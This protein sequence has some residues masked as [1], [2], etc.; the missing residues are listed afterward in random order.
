MIDHVRQV[1]LEDV[2]VDDERGRL[3]PGRA[4][5]DADQI[6]VQ[7]RHVS[8]AVARCGGSIARLRAQD[9]VDA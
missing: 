4:A 6:F 3:Q 1:A 8:P 2:K 9:K 7:V 5:R